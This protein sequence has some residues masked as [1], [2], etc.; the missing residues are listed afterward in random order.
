MKH[1]REVRSKKKPFVEERNEVK[2]GLVKSTVK[3]SVGEDLR[4]QGVGLNS[5]AKGLSDNGQQAQQLQNLDA[6]DSFVQH[7]LPEDQVSAVKRQLG[8]KAREHIA[9]VY[10]VRRPIAADPSSLQWVLGL[11]ISW[12][13]RRR[14]K[15]SEVV[16]RLAA[17]EWPVPLVFVTLDGRFAPWLKKLRAV[18]GARVA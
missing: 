4:T 10:L 17:M 3:G 9:E 14:G 15:Q 13:G 1:K 18:S 16:D 5:V 12:W 2:Q 7:G 11:R 6:K 8:G